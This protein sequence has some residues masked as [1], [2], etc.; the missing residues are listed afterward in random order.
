[1]SVLLQTSAGDIVIDLFV[2]ESPRACLNFLKLCKHRYYDFSP[3]FN[4]EKNAHV[5][6]G[7]PDF[8][9]NYTEND[10]GVSIWGLG[11]EEQR[12]KAGSQKVVSLKIGL[13]SFKLDQ[14][15]FGSRFQISLAPQSEG[16]VFGTV[17]E[18]F[19][20]LDTVNRQPVDAEGRFEQDIRIIHTYILDDPFDDV[21]DVPPVP[22]PSKTQL[23]TV[24]GLEVRGVELDMESMDEETRERYIRQREAESR[25]LTLELMGDIPAATAKPQENVLFVCKLNPITEDDD[26]RLIFSRFGEIRSCEIIKD[27]KTRLS[28]CYAFIEFATKESCEQAYFKM[29]SVLIDDR[30]IKV[31]FSQSVA[32]STAKWEEGDKR[33]HEGRGGERKRHRD[34]SGRQGA[35]NLGS[36]RDYDKRSNDY[37]KKGYAEKKDYGTKPRDREEDRRDSRQHEG[38][39]RRSYRERESGKAYF[40]RSDQGRDSEKSRSNHRD[41][42]RYSRSDRDGDSDKHSRSN[43]Y[44]NTLLSD[45]NASSYSPRSEKRHT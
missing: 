38:G 26:L 22:R 6:S 39:S 32:S 43:R 31:D 25:S 18:G 13:V 17:A 9:L 2:K 33:G 8:P 7:L 23:S 30:R 20:T 24:R 15:A 3:L 36:D 42:A 10:L 4:L 29:D 19:D 45:R 1:M 12:P 44:R 41:L 40:S 28:L 37:G 16:H 27:S 5:E 34:E 21:A 35:Y 11:G 14:S